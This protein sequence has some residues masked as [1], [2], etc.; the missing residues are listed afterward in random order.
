MSADFTAGS[1][2]EYLDV[3][4]SGLS[5]LDGRLYYRGQSKRII[6]GY[7]LKPSIDTIT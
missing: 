7:P 3:I 1:F 4:Q 2:E 6:E 5:K